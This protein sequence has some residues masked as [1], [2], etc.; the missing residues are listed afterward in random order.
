MYDPPRTGRSATY[1]R[2]HLSVHTYLALNGALI[3]SDESKGA[4][5]TRRRLPR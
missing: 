5:G 2:T 1:V 3:G 4:P